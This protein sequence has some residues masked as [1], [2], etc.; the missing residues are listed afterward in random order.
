MEYWIFKNLPITKFD[1]EYFENPRN[2]LYKIGEVFCLVFIYNVYK[3]N[4]FTIEIED[5]RKAPQKPSLA[6][7]LFYKL[8]WK[9]IYKYCFNQ[10]FTSFYFAFKASIL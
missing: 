5:G 8:G 9:Q 1:F 10:D 3:E 6:T 4:M 7:F 2:F